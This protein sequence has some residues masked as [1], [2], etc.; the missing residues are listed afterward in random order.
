MGLIDQ[1]D[2]EVQTPRDEALD[3]KSR[4]QSE[5]YFEKELA[6]QSLANRPGT[7]KPKRA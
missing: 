2:L 5:K 4:L 1:S 6:K 3:L 7:A